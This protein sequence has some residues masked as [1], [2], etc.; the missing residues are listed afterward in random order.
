MAQKPTHEGT[1]LGS[2]Q[3]EVSAESSPLLEFLAVHAQSI[4]AGIVLFILAIGGYW[5]YSSYTASQLTAQQQ[6]F[7]KIVAA[8]QGEARLRALEAYLKTAP[9]TIRLTAL[10]T[11]AQS[12]QDIGDYKTAYSAWEQLAKQQPDLRV[13]ATSG[14]AQALIEQGEKQKALQLL[15]A[16]IPGLPASYQIHVNSQIVALAETMG[17]YKRAVAACE[18]IIQAPAKFNVPV[19]P[20]KLGFWSQRLAALQL[21][22]QAA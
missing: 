19:S 21:R 6:E 1:L 10:L 4:I 17:D 18:A 9:D 13:E 15:D 2:I 11:L 14:M 12:A 22:L 20:T 7:S 8:N 16:L 5:A 3:S